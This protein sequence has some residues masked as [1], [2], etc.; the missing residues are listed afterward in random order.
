MAGNRYCIVIGLIGQTVDDLMKET[1]KKM[2]Y[3]D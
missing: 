3:M 1:S 2:P